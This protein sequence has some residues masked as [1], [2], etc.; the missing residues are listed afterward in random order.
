MLNSIT[1][2]SLPEFSNNSVTPLRE[3]NAKLFLAT[4][5]KR[6][7]QNSIFVSA[8]FSL[9][10][11][12]V[13]IILYVLMPVVIWVLPIFVPLAL[14]SAVYCIGSIFE[15]KNASADVKE[16]K[17]EVTEEKEKFEKIQGRWMETMTAQQN[18]QSTPIFA[19]Q[20][21]QTEI[22]SAA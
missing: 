13:A 10:F 6:I 19:E 22:A 17:Q 7:T 18:A 5:E 3:A 2:K 12:S 11:T 14:I 8:G 1:R 21:T 4:R 20:G 15:F 16:Y 9:A